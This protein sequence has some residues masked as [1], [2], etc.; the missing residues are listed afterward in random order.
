MAQNVQ[1]TFWSIDPVTQS[2]T[3]LWVNS[4]STVFNTT[5]AYD[6]STGALLLLGDVAQFTSV[7]E[8]PTLIVSL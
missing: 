5:L 7:F 3:A 1:T 8:A 2:L 4:D 6:P